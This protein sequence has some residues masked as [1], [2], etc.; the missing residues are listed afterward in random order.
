MKRFNRRNFSG[1]HIVVTGA[2][3]G[4][5]RALAEQLALEKGAHLSVLDITDS[6]LTEL[7]DRLRRTSGCEISTHVVDVA[8][9]HSVG[10]WLEATQ[11]RPV[12]GL[13]N[14]AGVLGLG[15]F[16]DTSPKDFEK[17]LEVNF[18]G[19]VRMTRLMLPRLQRAESGFIVNVASAAGLVATPGMAAYTTSKFALVGFSQ[20]LRLELDPKVNVLVVCP[21]FVRTNLFLTAKISEGD[22][23]EQARNRLNQVMERFGASPARVAHSI[24]GAAERNR[25]MLLVGLDAHLLY[26]G[27]R[28]FP[29]MTGALAGRIYKILTDRGIVPS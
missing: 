2:A 16:A 6:P 22:E 10:K 9:E 27:Q 3:S 14:C 11:D 29:S 28:F 12:D 7:A 26:L 1:R 8:S 25:G 5:G 4:I 19:A 21:G 13:I 15:R 17:V 18:L 20:V 23:K 24:I